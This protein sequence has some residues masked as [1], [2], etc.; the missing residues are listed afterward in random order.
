MGSIDWQRFCLLLLLLLLLL[1]YAAYGMM[2]L[3]F[4][5]ALRICYILIPLIALCCFLHI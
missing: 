5:C 1:V 2:L 3:Y 4:D